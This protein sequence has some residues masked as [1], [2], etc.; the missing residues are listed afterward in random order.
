MKELEEQLERLEKEILIERNKAG[1]K[2]T[3][4]EIR[5]Y[6]KE[7]LIKEPLVLINYLIKEI[8]LYNDKVEIIL[9]SPIKSSGNQGFS[10]LAI[11]KDFKKI[12]Q[13]YTD[14]IIIEMNI[15]FYI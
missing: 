3:E 1:I 12:K 5:K 7:A 6:Y 9:N 10:F 15:T 11:I 13:H 2:I 8:K 14:P 4:E